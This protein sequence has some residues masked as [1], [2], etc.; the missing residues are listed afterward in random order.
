M[1]HSANEMPGAMMEEPAAAKSSAQ[2]NFGE[3]FRATAKQGTNQAPVSS[4][5]TGALPGE[6]HP[7]VTGPTGKMPG[8]EQAAL[9]GAPGKMPGE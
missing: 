2:I 6:K 1:Q 5:E 8:E 7:G 3:L 4:S 9:P